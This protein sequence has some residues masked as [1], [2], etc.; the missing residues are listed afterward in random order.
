[1]K[2]WGQ[3]EGVWFVSPGLPIDAGTG[4]LILRGFP[5]TVA[6]CMQATWTVSG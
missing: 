5:P 6:T 3:C 1:M 2:G 4:A